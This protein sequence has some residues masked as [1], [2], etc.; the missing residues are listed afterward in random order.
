MDEIII[1]WKNIY[2]II[3]ILDTTP[4]IITKKYINE[5]KKC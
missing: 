4:K 5:A 2:Q 1:Y 3:N